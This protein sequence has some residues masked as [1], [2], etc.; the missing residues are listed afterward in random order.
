MVPPD[1]KKQKLDEENIK[2][3]EK[4]MN[5][6]AMMKNVAESGGSLGLGH[7][8]KTLLVVGHCLVNGN[9][10]TSATNGSRKSASARHQNLRARPHW[11]RG[12][13]SS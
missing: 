8:A 2:H 6:M 7:C 12:W 9:G 5:K 3:K 1:A 13:G 4:K 11:G 10:R